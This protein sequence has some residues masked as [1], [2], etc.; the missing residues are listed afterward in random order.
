MTDDKFPYMADIELARLR[1]DLK[2]PRVSADPDSQREAYEELAR[3]QG[4]KLLAMCKHIAGHGLNP[5]ERFIVIPDDDDNFIVL[6]A[7]RRLTALRALEQPE[8]LKD[9]IGETEL[10][11]LR[12]R[13]DAWDPP[14]GVPCVVFGR[15]E[16]ADPWIELAH[17][18][19]ADGAGRVEWTAQQKARHRARSGPKPVHLQVL[20][21]T[22]NEGSLS[23]ETVRRYD[24]GRY[25]VST[26]VR[27]LSTPHVRDQLG[28]KVEAGIVVTRYPKSEVL[29][30]LT[31][32]VDEIGTG[33]KKV[34]TFMSRAQREA[35]VDDFKDDD[36]PEASTAGDVDLPLGA[37]PARAQTKPARRDRKAS[38]TRANTIPKDFTAQI[39]VA[40]I[41]EIYIELK[42]KLRVNEVPN[43]SGV[44]LRVF[45]ELS[46]DEYVKRNAIPV[47]P[48]DQLA[49][50]GVKVANW[51]EASGILTKKELT[52]VREAMKD[53]QP[54]L[55]TNL[56]QLVHNPLMSVAGNDVKALWD[57]LS[58]FMEKL[59]L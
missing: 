3:E 28:I 6:D 14:D 10:R 36:L 13:S 33:Q 15:R 52:S 7:N 30:G 39:D 2:N 11:Q 41:N 31:K 18:G 9:V 26:L 42:R 29:K 21:F 8:L 50:K 59:W 45:V 37:A 43:A 35:Y 22:R 51:M 57:R 1:L 53:S 5:A 34:A 4:S 55:A 58:H 46:V 44:L 56:N 16:D 17:Q 20:E 47:K 23:P 40:R 27:V 25:P 38:A 24:S 54:S 32:I 48:N 19:E 12:A 49:D